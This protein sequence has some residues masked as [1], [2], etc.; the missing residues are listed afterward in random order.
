MNINSKQ[1]SFLELF[2]DVF[3][4]AASPGAEPP[5]APATV[6]LCVLYDWKNDERFE[7]TALKG[8]MVTM[9]SQHST[10]QHS[11]AQHSTVSGSMR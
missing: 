5:D 8:G 10:A 1:G 3:A 7:F 2:D 6:P 11:T 4:D 9:A